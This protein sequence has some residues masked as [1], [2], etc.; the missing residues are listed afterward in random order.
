[1]SGKISDIDSTLALLDTTADQ[2]AVMKLN[3]I[4]NILGSDLFGRRR[5]RSEESRIKYFN[6]LM[7]K[8][9]L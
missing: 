8:R 9:S 1:M 7:V 4:K 5:K 3:F 6:D 2:D